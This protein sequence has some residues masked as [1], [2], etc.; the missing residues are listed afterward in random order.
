M[1]PLHICRYTFLLTVLVTV[2]YLSNGAGNML[3]V[4]SVFATAILDS[5]E[6]DA[7]PCN[8]PS[9]NSMCVAPGHL[10][11]PLM[12]AVASFRTLNGV[13]VSGYVNLFAIISGTYTY[14]LMQ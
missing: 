6:R 14:N 10:W 13:T 12:T 4:L 8:V 2:W 5:V 3:G 1:S 11:G 9:S 7:R